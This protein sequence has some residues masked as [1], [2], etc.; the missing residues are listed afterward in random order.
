MRVLKSI[1]QY[2]N[3]KTG[4][5]FLLLFICCISAYVVNAQYTTD[6]LE[7]AEAPAE[8]DGDID[9][10]QEDSENSLF[11][12]KKETDPLAVNQRNLPRGFTKK[13][14]EDDAFW[15]ADGAEGAKKTIASVP[16]GS[17]GSN[18]TKEEKAIEE[19]I[20]I[21][22]S[23]ISKYQRNQEEKT[24]EKEYVS[25]SKQSWV[26]TLLW[27]LVIAGFAGILAWYLITNNIHFRK[28]K[29]DKEELNP[30]EM[31]E[32]IFAINYMS[33]VDKAV[34][35][36]NY[37]LAI[38]LQYLRMLKAMAERN[39]IRYKQDKTN[40]DYMMELQ[41][42]VFYNNFFRTT[43]HYEFAWYGN[44]PVSQETYILVRHGF[45]DFENQI[46]G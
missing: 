29:K 19:E 36:G 35:Q 24:A 26:Q 16:V 37:R 7:V 46:T 22:T 4:S 30:A 2:I 42:T 3:R 38:R 10:E 1:I 11:Q 20:R 18:E 12:N 43:R 39:I 27:I 15:Y 13:L 44:F 23:G 32:D 25:V 33:E 41:P 6:T 17:K 45:D 8:Y 34:A 14:K 21:D 28:K 31:P 40:L 5:K 9:E